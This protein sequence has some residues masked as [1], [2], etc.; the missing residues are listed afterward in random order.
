MTSA[1]LAQGSAAARI[2]DAGTRLD[3]LLVT[4]GAWL[5]A[6]LWILPLLFALWAAFHPPLYAARFDLT[7][8]LTLDNFTRAMAAA[9]FARYMLN[10]LMLVTTRRP[11]TRHSIGRANRNDAPLRW[12]SWIGWTSTCRR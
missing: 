12:I 9:P 10:T 5:L 6:V 8:P 3:H 1:A 2:V 11:S 7:A 4:A